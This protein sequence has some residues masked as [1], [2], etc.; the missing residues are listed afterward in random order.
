MSG[1]PLNMKVKNLA[2]R[3][4]FEP[5][6]RFPV[7]LIS[8][9]H[10]LPSHCLP[11]TKKDDHSKLCFMASWSLTT[12]NREQFSDKTRTIFLEHRI[13]S[14]YESLMATVDRRVKPES[15]RMGNY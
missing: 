15:L 4:G 10:P 2:E 1:K 3:E 12:P 13:A 7:H 9:S 11:Q 8:R 6:V 14:N 5:P